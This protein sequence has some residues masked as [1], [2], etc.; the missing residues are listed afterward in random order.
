MKRKHILFIISGLILFSLCLI[1]I[2]V[3]QVVDG[4]VAQIQLARGNDYSSMGEYD[5]ALI[6]YSE[7]LE[8]D[9]R[10]VLVYINRAQV[11]VTKGDFESAMVDY[12]NALAIAPGFPAIYLLRA[13]ANL[14]RKEYEV[15]ITD[16]N[17]AL[18]LMPTLARAYLVRGIARWNLGHH[19]EAKKDFESATVLGM[20]VD[21]DALPDDTP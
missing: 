7:S 20:Y 16:C 19:E 1:T 11:Y 17:R 18:A 6:E 8:H 10:L 12:D 4:F 14:V 15:T 3:C 5:K 2:G 13:D 9:P 21:I